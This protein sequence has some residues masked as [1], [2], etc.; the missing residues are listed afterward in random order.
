MKIKLYPFS[1]ELKADLSKATEKLLE[2]LFSKKQT[3]NECDRML[4]L[5]Q[6]EINKQYISDGTAEYI[7]HKFI[8]HFKSGFSG[9]NETLDKE[10]T[11]NVAK[12]SA[13]A[14]EHTQNKDD[15]QTSDKPVDKDFLL[16]WR[17]AARLCSHEEIQDLLG[18]ILAEEIAEPNIFSYTTL[19]VIKSL[20]KDDL[21]LFRKVSPYIFNK[22]YLYDP[23]P[24]FELNQKHQ[25]GVHRSDIFN[26]ANCGLINESLVFYDTKSKKVE[27][28]LESGH[29]MGG[30][31][32]FY[33]F[34]IVLDSTNFVVSANMLTKAGEEIFN[35]FNVPAPHDPELLCHFA[36]YIKIRR[37]KSK[38]KKPH[39]VKICKSINNKA[40]LNEEIGSIIVG[41]QKL[42]MQNIAKPRVI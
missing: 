2:I 14:A 30:M 42:Y 1:L 39:S 33:D 31:I 34:A 6:A 23:L 36:Q 7:N 18:K 22:K 5:A 26:L 8:N 11:T 40:K 38:K 37:D 35:V 27:N 3:E 29:H 12:A 24:L 16:K 41:S 25:I 4:S 9:F 28:F 10:A 20:K 17:E 19:E 13:F 15:S 21:D 32:V